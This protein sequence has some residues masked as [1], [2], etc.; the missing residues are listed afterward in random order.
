MV[1]GEKYDLLLK[2]GRVICPASGI[3]GNYDVAIRDGRIAA[4]ERNIVPADSIAVVHVSGKLVLPGLIDTHAHVYQYVTGPIRAGSGHGR[5]SLG[6]HDG[7]RSRRHLLHDVAGFQALHRRKVRDAGSGVL[8]CLSRRRPRRSL[9]SRSLQSH[10]RKH[11][12]HGHVSLGEQGSNTR[13]QGSRRNR[14]LRQVGHQGHGDG[15]GDR[16]SLG[17]SPLRSFRDA[18]GITGKRSERRRRR[19]NPR[20]GHSAPSSR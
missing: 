16:P 5:R 13:H 8:V 10:R 20:T 7:R 6:R 12:S 4:V 19:Y 14:R 18:L 2:G 11:R 17:S 3:D 15:G 9:L 1:A